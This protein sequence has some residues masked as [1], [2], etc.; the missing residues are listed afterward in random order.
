MR[1]DI[2]AIR[3]E[4]TQAELTEDS[5]SKD[6]IQQFEKWFQ[7]A[8]NSEMVEPFLRIFHKAVANLED[9]S[10]HV[11]CFTNDT[12]VGMTLSELEETYREVDVVEQENVI[13]DSLNYMM[14]VLKNNPQYGIHVVPAAASDDD[15]GIDAEKTTSSIRLQYL[16]PQVGWFCWFYITFYA[17]MSYAKIRLRF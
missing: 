2:A 15:D 1:E 5:V 10:A 6:P 17:L 4:Y 3:K 7:E 8:L 14:N 13:K 12:Y 11:K 9:H 16:Y